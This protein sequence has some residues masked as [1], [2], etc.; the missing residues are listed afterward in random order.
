MY[1]RLNKIIKGCDIMIGKTIS[2]YNADYPDIEK[3]RRTCRYQ[4]VV[5]CPTCHFAIE[6]KPLGAF[7][8]REDES[9]Y[10]TYR[11][12]LL[13]LCK[14]CRQIFMSEFCGCSYEGFGPIYSF[15]SPEYSAP[16]TP[17]NSAISEAIKEMSPNFAETYIQS[18]AAE[19]QQLFQICGVGYRKALEYLVKDYLCHK[20][21]DSTDVICA[22]LLG[23][24]LRRID[25]PR[26]KTLAERT[27]WIG[28][29][30]THYIRKH[31]D[32]SI[33]DMKRFIKALLIYIESE[34]AFEEA[35]GI[36]RK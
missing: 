28:N 26:I 17:H 35:L 20:Y 25:D 19:S 32:L 13:C 1:D 10:E 31:E 21:P 14:R 16:T 2:A 33:N 22:E 12:N 29:D 34:L 27:T 24:S 18:E 4:E 7:F 9:Q 8:I 6:P 15:S 3:A 23:A 30:E 5:E 11:L 36:D